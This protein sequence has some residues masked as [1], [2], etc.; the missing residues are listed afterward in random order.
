MR[1]NCKMVHRFTGSQVHRFTGSQVHRFTGSLC[2]NSLL[3]LLVL[4]L[5]VLLCLSSA[6]ADIITVDENNFPDEVFRTRLKT[7]TNQGYNANNNT[8]N[9]DSVTQI[10]LREEELGTGNVKISSLRGIEKFTKL[11]TIYIEKNQ[12][13]L[14]EIDLSNRA[15]LTTVVIRDNPGGITKLNVSGCNK[16]TTFHCNDNNLEELNL[17][18][19]TAVA[20]FNMSNNTSTLK[21]IN[22]SGCTALSAQGFENFAGLEELNLN[23]CKNLSTV[24]FAGS[25]ITSLDLTGC[26]KLTV[27]NIANSGLEN[28]K[29]DGCTGFTEFYCNINKLKALDVSTC[30][31]LELLHC[32][33]NPNL[34]ELDV[35][36]LKK[37]KTLYCNQNTSMTTLKVT[38]CEALE[39]L[40]LG[41]DPVAELDVSNLK[42][43]KTLECPNNYTASMTKLNITGC[44]GLITL[45]CRGQSISELDTPSCEN[46]EVLSCD[47]NKIKAL[48]LSKNTK[49]EVLS[50]RENFLKE[51]DT[52]KLESLKYLNCRKNFLTDLDLS[53]NA[54]LNSLYCS[55]Q[56]FDADEF[57]VTGTGKADYPYEASFKAFKYIKDA[58]RIESVKGFI[59]ANDTFD[60]VYDAST[61]TAKFI[62]KPEQVIYNIKIKCANSNVNDTVMDVTLEELNVT[63]YVAPEPEIEEEAE[64]GEDDNDNKDD[65]DSDNK[66]E[67]DAVIIKPMPVASDEIE[68]VPTSNEGKAEVYSGDL[69][70][71]LQS[72][73][74]NYSELDYQEIGNEPEEAAQILNE[75]ATPTLSQNDIMIDS[76]EKTQAL[77]F[78]TAAANDT[79]F[80]VW[81]INPASLGYT[82]YSLWATDGMQNGKQYHKPSILNNM[83]CYGP[84]LGVVKDGSVGIDIKNLYYAE[85]SDG[86]AKKSRGLIPSVSTVFYFKSVSSSSNP[87]KAASKFRTAENESETFKSPILTVE[88]SLSESEL[89]ELEELEAQQEQEQQEQAQEQEEEQEPIFMIETSSNGSSGGC[90]SGSNSLLALALI[91]II[92]SFKFIKFI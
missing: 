85:N 48:D 23:G 9:T 38:G 88:A 51:L 55:G 4:T 73:D 36:N 83:L 30:T 75:T 6:W 53:E 92:F 7:Y 59:A 2:S 69:A 89:A 25:K 65:Y 91:F 39:L 19:C 70:A 34:T 20:E 60:A 72:R 79:V 28:L 56:V 17:S 46:L 63:E 35:S 62:R 54:A 44:E 12:N 61:Q 42:Q 81:L 84:F 21:K 74:I 11:A 87:A 67:D 37:L 41:N 29:I 82:G 64:T 57:N 22:V 77:A 10:L 18:G 43:L 78:K 32:E 1:Q 5:S 16:L 80:Y 58:G 8:I 40:N 47:V 90:N 76:A 33:V 52:S 49:L 31:N 68:F 26:E 3:A 50:C 24:S 27:V 66:T 86:H 15:E 13:K 71:D 45:D 14:D